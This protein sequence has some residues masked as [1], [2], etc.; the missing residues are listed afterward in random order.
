MNPMKY[1]VDGNGVYLGGWDASP[2]DGAIEV[3]TAPESAAQV[4]DFDAVAFMP[5]D[6]WVAIRAERDARLAATD[7]CSIRAWDQGDALPP[8]VAE[9]RQA[10]RDITLQEDPSNIEWPEGLV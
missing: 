2:P 1:Y 9:Y 7:W 6:P 8:N 10:L 5:L 4:W 3:P